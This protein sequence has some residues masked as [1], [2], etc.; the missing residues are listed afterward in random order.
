MTGDANVVPLRNR[1]TEAEYEQERQRLRDTYGN[2]SVE[3]AAKRDQALA[4]LFARSN[5]TQEELAAKEGKERSFVAR[6]LVFGRFLN[7]VSADTKFETLPTNLS[8][9]KFR[10]YWAAADK[11]GGNER[12]RFAAVLKAMAEHTKLGPLRSGKGIPEKIR[13]AFGDGRWHTDEAI[14][15]HFAN[16]HSEGDI[17]Q[18][19]KDRANRNGNSFRVEGERFSRGYRYRIFKQGR[20]I[21]SEEIAAKLQPLIKDLKEQGRSNMATMSPGTVARLAALLQRVVDEWKQ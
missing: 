14:V 1:M 18:A 17:R 20:M 5:W 16:E 8:E 9:F 19:L 13:D 2:S 12:Q 4:L 11:M 7:F 15:A 6:R 21:S 10:K 3:A